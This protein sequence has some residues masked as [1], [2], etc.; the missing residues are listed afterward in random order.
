VIR[1]KKEFQESIALRK[2]WIVEERRADYPTSGKLIREYEADIQQWEKCLRELPPDELELFNKDLNT[3]TA[4]AVTLPQTIHSYDDYRQVLEVTS[5]AEWKVMRPTI[6]DVAA[7]WYAAFGGGSIKPPKGAEAEEVR[8]AL[9]ARASPVELTEK[10]QKLRAASTEAKSGNTKL[11]KAQDK[12][13]KMLS[14]RQEAIAVLTGL[15]QVG[16]PR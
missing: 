11:K 13:R 3:P 1:L 16:P 9:A 8:K 6:V 14:V 12:L 7:A 5:D 10:L 2:Q 4:D 15:L